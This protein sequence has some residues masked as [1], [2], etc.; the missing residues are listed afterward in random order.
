MVEL[1]KHT[2]FSNLFLKT[3]TYLRAVG[4]ATMSCMLLIENPFKHVHEM[5]G[6]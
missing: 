5:G 3:P 1:F 2:I 6:R 4:W